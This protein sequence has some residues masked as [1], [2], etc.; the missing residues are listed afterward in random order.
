MSFPIT[1]RG[2]LKVAKGKASGTI[3]RQWKINIWSRP[4]NSSSNYE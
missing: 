3:N 1:A 4:G 2:Q